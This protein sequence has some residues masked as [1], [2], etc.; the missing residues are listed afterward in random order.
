M[1]SLT[2]RAHADGTDPED[3]STNPTTAPH[4]MAIAEARLSRRGVLAGGFLA[5]AGF[6]TAGLI[7]P[8]AAAAHPGHGGRPGGGPQGSRLGFEAIP[9]STLDEVVVPRGYTARPFIPWGTPLLGAYPAFRPGTPSAG[10][11]GYRAVCR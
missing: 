6:L 9:P 8:P 3:L 1:T 11:P 4:L 2:E 5:A 10:V 7:D